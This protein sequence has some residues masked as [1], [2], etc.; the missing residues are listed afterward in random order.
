MAVVSKL[1]QNFLSAVTELANRTMLFIPS[2]CGVEGRLIVKQCEYRGVTGDKHKVYYPCD[3]GDNLSM[4]AYVLDTIQDIQIGSIP[5]FDGL[6]LTGDLIF[7]DAGSGLPFGSCSMYH[8]NWSQVAVQNTW[9]NVSDADFINGQSNTVTH[10]GN[11]KLTVTK[12]GI[13]KASV[14]LDLEVSVSNKHAEIGFE[15]SG[16]GSAATEGIVCKEAPGS[17]QELNMATTAL[18]DLDVDDTVEPCVRTIDAGNPTI[19]VDCVSFNLVQI[20]GTQPN[21]I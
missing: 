9:Y 17:N 21:I 18:L 19:T 3:I 7:T 2:E 13:Y 4:P 11:G 15:I 20:G 16:S 6:F 12:K 14:A 10:D 1:R 8:G 5:T